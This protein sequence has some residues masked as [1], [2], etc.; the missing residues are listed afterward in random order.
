MIEEFGAIRHGHKHEAGGEGTTNLA[1]SGLSPEDQQIWAETVASRNLA[2]PEITFENVPLIK[3]LANNIYEGLPEGP[4]TVLF[5]STP[6]PRAQMTAELTAVYLMKKAEGGSKQ[7][8]VGFVNEA[9]EDKQTSKDIV[10]VSYTSTKM[11]GRMK[12]LAAVDAADDAKLAAYLNATGGNTTHSN[13]QAMV[14]RVVNEDLA[15]PDSVFK[16]R[17]E[18]LKTQIAEYTE[19]F[20]DIPGPVFLYGVGHHTNVITLDIAVNGRTRYDSVE[21]VPKPLELIRAK[22]NQ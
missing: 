2:N 9:K 13:E 1:E 14:Q 10:D 8:N 11:M 19:R 15:S 7:V 21:E 17:A 5:T 16:R 22:L 18:D 6:Y 4:S 3:D 20:K 12:E